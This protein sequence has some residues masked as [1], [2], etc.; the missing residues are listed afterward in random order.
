MLLLFSEILKRERKKQGL[1]QERLAEKLNVEVRTVRDWEHGKHKPLVTFWKNLQDLFT[2]TPEELGLVNTKEDNVVRSSP[3]EQKSVY[4]HPSLTIEALP[5]D[6]VH[7][8]EAF[9]TLKKSILQR[10][11]QSLTAITSALKGAG[12]YGKTTLAKALCHDPEIQAS[13][14]SGIF[15]ITLGE[16]LKPGDLVSKVKE[17]IY[18]LTRTNPPVE[19]LE[20]A[21]IE[22]RIALEERRLLVVLDDVWSDRDLK[23]FLQGGS[24]CMRLV[25]TRNEGILPF[26][27]SEVQVDAMSPEEAIQLLY[28]GAGSADD[29]KA[30]EKTLYKL[31]RSL[32][33]WPLLIHL[34]NGILR[35]VLKHHEDLSDALAFLERELEK[36]GVVAF[37]SHQPLERHDAVARTLE[38]SFNLLDKVDY[39]LYMQLAIF[40]ED[41]DIPFEIVQRL[42]NINAPVDQDKV[43]ATCLRLYDLSLLHFIDMKQRYIRLHDV[44]RLYLHNKTR[45]TLPFLQQDFLSALRPQRWADLSLENTYFWKYL[46]LHLKEAKQPH[47]LFETVTDLRY[48]AKKIFVYHGAYAA[49]ADIEYAMPELAEKEELSIL[50]ELLAKIGDLLYIC[51]SVS[52]LEN[53]LIAYISQLGSF[54]RQCTRLREEIARPC[55]LAWYPFP[56]NK[57]AQIIR[58]LRGHEGSVIYC[59]LSPDNKRIISA[60]VDKTLKVWNMDTGALR[61]TLQGHTEALTGCAITPDG[62]RIISTSE[63]GTIR[64]WNAYSGSELLVITGHEGPVTGCALSSDGAWLATTSADRTIKLWNI[65]KIYGPPNDGYAAELTHTLQGHEGLVTCCAISA[66]GSLLVSASEDQTLRFWDIKTGQELL[67]PIVPTMEDGDSIYACAISADG[68]SLIFTC[69]IGLAVWDVPTRTERFTAFGHPGILLGCTLSPDERWMLSASVDGS[70]KGW[71]T[72]QDIDIFVFFGHSDNVNWCAINTSSD[73]MVSASDDQTL[74]IWSVPPV[75]ETRLSD[76]EEFAFALIACAIDPSGNWAIALTENGEL[77]R[78][79]FREAVERETLTNEAHCSARCPISPNGLWVVTSYEKGIALWDTLTGANLQVFEGHTDIVNSCAISPDGTWLVTASKDQTLRIWD[80]ETGQTRHI[81]T[82]HTD[83]VNS[84]AISSDGKWIVSASHDQAI[85]IWEAQTGILYQTL[86][87]SPDKDFSCMFLPARD[88]IISISRSGVTLWNI[89]KSD[90]ILH[91]FSL[92]ENLHAINHYA[93]SPDGQFLLLITSLGAPL[94]LWNIAQG[95]CVTTFYTRQSVYDCAFHP[96]GNH[97][98]VAAENGLYFFTLFSEKDEKLERACN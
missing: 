68:T 81:L 72:T 69:G 59:I 38:I 66:H 79:N 62:G 3:T 21:T 11:G 18:S 43:V 76:N 49:E 40:P 12:G 88:V 39:D 24:D 51:D 28:Y 31:V 2:M 83:T 30:H 56:E 92:T 74:K 5:Q 98:I 54:S 93:I 80:R 63:D 42:W 64:I 85:K 61:M 60:S 14:P 34:V 13:F 27:V 91:S 4:L 94:Q 26:G 70:I 9:N 41:A 53:M 77:L 32:K 29:F 96:D 75:I 78:W 6:Y 10:D 25:T 86:P 19:S 90:S 55:F 95:Q 37:D 7:R 71:L 33:E 47:I 87:G 65:C 89:H 97:F 8:P 20:I 50:K 84:C 36:H 23:P 73:R 16:N 17:L 46:I 82:S 48:L 57:G 44:I 35:K 15:W 52:D 1:S 67:P 58:T 22:L 45:Q